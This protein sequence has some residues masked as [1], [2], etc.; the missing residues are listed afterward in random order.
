MDEI[1]VAEALGEVRE[2]VT[3]DG[4]ELELVDVD[5]SSGGITLRLILEDEACRE[6][7]MPRLLLEGVA[8]DMIGARVAGLRSV[9]VQDPRES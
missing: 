7:V 5:A 3:V 1:E 6:C 8:L 9:S 2:L 4:G